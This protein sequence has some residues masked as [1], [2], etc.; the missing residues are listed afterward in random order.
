MEDK[1]T[2]ILND[3]TDINISELLGREEVQFDNTIAS[4]YIRGK[5]VMVTG[6][7]GSIGSEILRQLVKLEP[8]RIVAIDIYENGIY[9]TQ[10]DLIFDGLNNVDL[11]VEIMSVTD[12][13]KLALLHRKY[14]PNIVFHAAAHKHL[15]FMENNPEE[16]VKN[17]VFGS[18]ITMMLSEKYN[19]KKY[20]LISTDK[21]A[22]PTSV[23]GA[24]KRI[25]ELIMQTMSAKSHRTSY[26]AVRF[27]NVIESNGSVI[28]LLKRQLKKGGPLTITHKDMERYMMTIP[29]AVNLVLMAGGIANNGEIFVLDMGEQVNILSLAENLIR[30]AGLTPYKDIDIKFTGVR[31]GEKLSE[32]LITENESLQKTQIDKIYKLENKE[33]DYDTFNENLRDLE[34]F[35]YRNESELIMK[36]LKILLPEYKDNKI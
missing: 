12:F 7:G 17:N 26:C 27:G 23:L 30:H 25:T 8:K 24:T 4:E 6:A 11:V 32:Q 21:A 29:E 35:T 36:Q 34:D 3:K 14:K 33:F 22:N 18:A 10:Q 15:P 31:A 20:I 1:N 16:A 13:D 28:P 19:V 9:E 5:V 2:T